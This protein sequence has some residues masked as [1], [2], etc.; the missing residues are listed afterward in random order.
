[1]TLDLGDKVLAGQGRSIDLSAQ[2]VDDIADGFIAWNGVVGVLD[3]E[4]DCT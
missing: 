1:M 3:P 4:L 2:G